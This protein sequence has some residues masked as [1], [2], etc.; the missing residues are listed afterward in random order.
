MPDFMYVTPDVLASFESEMEKQAFLG[1][2]GRRILG[3]GAKKGWGWA[4]KRVGQEAAQTGAAGA[5]RKGAQELAGEA[6][7]QAAKRTGQ[8]AVQRSAQGATEEV[9]KRTGQQ[10]GQALKPGLVRG[11]RLGQ[12]LATQ[13]GGI[14]AGAGLG[15]GVGGVGGAGA[16]AV[17]GYQEAK[18]KGESGAAGA[19]SGGMSGGWK[20]MLGGAAVGAA[21]GAKGGAASKAMAEVAGK[22][23]IGSTMARFGQRQVHAATGAT[24]GGHARLLAS[25]KVNPEYIK[26]VQGMRMGTGSGEA[27]KTFQSASKSHAL[28]PTAA[29]AKA[30]ERAKA[31]METAAK[32]EALGL[33]SVPGYAR[34]LTRKGGLKDVYNLGL[35][36]QWTQQGMMGKAMIALPAGFV[37]YEGV[38][39]TEKGG[40]G[41]GERMGEALGAGL[42]YA[43]TPF[44]PFLGSEVVGRGVGSVTGGV[45]KL[46][47][48]M[49]GNNPGKYQR[50]LGYNP[51]APQV[52]EGSRGMNVERNYS[53]RALGLPPED[54]MST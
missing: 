50:A 8:Q 27:L 20:G 41:K 16:G 23:G 33:T 32:G 45:G 47:D 19:I 49:F 26:A 11:T 18:E 7:E 22:K 46:F 13:A 37:G 24:P 17:K 40:P 9:A 4:T 31:T 21:L 38:T 53:N 44:I 2:I 34:H 10:V 3:Y 28:K 36:P 35:K 54:M 15:A 5:A 1:S 6:A 12:H 25:G 48:K 39:P 30:V 52:E 42:G 43:T 14:G 51:G 29:T